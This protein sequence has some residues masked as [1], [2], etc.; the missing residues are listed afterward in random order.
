[1]EKQKK[2]LRYR[3]HAVVHNSQWDNGCGMRYVIQKKNLFGWWRIS[4]EM[5]SE[6]EANDMC[7]ELNEYNSEK[8]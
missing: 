4:N 3:V 2:I 7:D 5:K 8:A 6:Q 1:M